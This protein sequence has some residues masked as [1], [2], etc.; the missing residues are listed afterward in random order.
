MEGSNDTPAWETCHFQFKGRIDRNLHG[1]GDGMVAMGMGGV[2][3]VGR[4][5]P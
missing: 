3:C 5:P 4:N 1:G 2:V